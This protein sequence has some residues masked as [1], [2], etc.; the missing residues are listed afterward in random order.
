MDIMAPA[1]I[2]LYL[3]VFG[4]RRDGYHEIGTLFERISVFDRIRLNIAE[5]PA[6]IIV[7]GEYV[8]TGEDSLLEKT[9]TGF[10]L[11]SGNRLD[12]NVELEKNIP[13][14]AGM[15]GGSSDAAALLLGLNSIT[16]NPLCEDKLE[17]IAGTLGADVPFFLKNASFAFGTGRGDVIEKARTS[18]KLGHVIVNPPVKVGTKSVYDKISGF[19]LT[20]DGAWATM[21]ALFLEKSD[22]ASLLKYLRNDLQQIVLREFPILEE[23]ISFLREA[24]AK[25]A[26][27][28]GSG[29]TVF[30][31]FDMGRLE[32]AAK[33]TKERFPKEEGWRVYDAVTV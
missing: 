3:G 32:E 18:L 8:P 24:G 12:F 4:K 10:N 14:A 29:P 33:K 11:A 15:G 26:M 25:C 9:I 2:N 1:K 23:V 31:I 16:G 17:E 19:N 28:T 13:V 30:G 22:Q 21:L 7:K 5:G 27:M 20:M 6:T